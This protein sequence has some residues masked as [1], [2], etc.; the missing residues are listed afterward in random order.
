MNKLCIAFCIVAALAA[1]S[2]FAQT[3]SPG[4]A[5]G[6]K[7]YK[8]AWYFPIPHPF[9]EA[10]QQGVKAFEKDMGIAVKQQIGV[11]MTQDSENNSIEALAAQNYRGFLV[12]PVDPSGANGL[13]QELA[14]HKVAV[15]NFGTSTV[16]PTPASFAVATDVKAAARTATENLIRLMG[17]KGNIIN[18]LEVLADANT[19]LRKQ[20][21]EEVVAAHP[22]VKIIQEVGDMSTIEEA[23]QKLES[24]IS[25]NLGKADGIICTGYTT[26]VAAVQVLKELSAKTPGK[27][28]A[29][30]GIDDD[31][32]V[33]DA[34]RTG[35]INGGTIAQ[36]PSGMGYIGCA[37][38]R[39]LSDGYAPKQGAYFINSGTVFV[40]KSNV[41]AYKKDLDEVTKS[42][43]ASLKDKYFND[44]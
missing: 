24:A 44:K 26:T 5:S 28:I 10:V 25:A 36:N 27:K 9:G 17:D 35:A 16:L 4:S 3:Q 42:I 40:T 2:G 33:L 29:L 15:V 31:P 12:Y 39:M 8:L 43:L 11:E 32:I 21:V 30:I 19:V 22:G 7:E 41:D 23:S 18:V 34:I 6:G 13:Y 1:G 20:G 38:L 14:A 37:L